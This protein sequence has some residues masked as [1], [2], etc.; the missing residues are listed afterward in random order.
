[1][2]LLAPAGTTDAF[3]AAVR[4]GADAV[5]IGAPALNAR[6]LA[7]DFTLAEIAAMVEEA[8]D[9]GVRVYAAMNALVKDAE[10]AAAVRLLAFFHSIGLD[11]V[12]LQDIGLYRLARRYFPDL[13]LHASTL[14]GANNHAHVEQLAAMGFARIV[15]AREMRL[16]EIAAVGEDKSCE[17]EVFVH[18]A[19]C[20]GV[21]GLCLFSSYLGGK[22]GLRGRCVQPCRR[23]YDWQGRGDGGYLFSMNDLEALPLVDDLRR[24]GV[25]SLKIEG[26]M[27]NASYV[28]HVVRA[29]RL[30]IDH[31]NDR[32]ALAE[33][34]SLTAAA[35]GRTTG[36]GYFPVTGDHGLISHR[37]SGNTGLFVGRIEAVRQ[38]RAVLSPRVTLAVGDRLRLHH[39]SSGDR[40]AFTVT[41]IEARPADRIVL[42]VPTQ[43]AAGDALY[44]IDTAAGGRG[45]ETK[46]FVPSHCR[47]LAAD[48][49][50]AP[51]VRSLMQRVAHEA[52]RPIKGGRQGRGERGGREH[53]PLWLK[54]DDLRH[55]THLPADWRPEQ[56]V[57]Q[58]SPDN[59]RRRRRISIP[60]DLASRLVLAL[61][62][63][64]QETDLW[65][66]EREILAQARRGQVDWQVA[67]IGQVRLFERL[68]ERLEREGAG[69]A[70]GFRG[71]G[72]GRRKKN[73]RHGR[74]PFS[75]FRLHGGFHLN[76]LNTQALKTARRAGLRSALTAIEADRGVVEALAA[77]KGDFVVGIT[78]YGRPALFISRAE[79]DFFRYNTVFVS[80][81]GERFSL[82]KGFGHTLALPERVFSLME[83]RGELAAMGLDY[84]VIDLCGIPPGRGVSPVLA[85][86]RPGGRRR[87]ENVG[88]F[89]YLGTLL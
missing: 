72:R 33:A 7:R 69:G 83:R 23:R 2:E 73:R 38:G 12:I 57:V 14:L 30:V 21:S 22:S 76:C 47:R 41:G 27:R 61:P 67:H 26:R 44:K 86:L 13:R 51:Q 4:A 79:A 64:I 11:A 77:G 84:G 8:H 16:D 87:K 40:H 85:D 78:V 6:A 49:D 19:M 46:N 62:P 75:G 17:I 28:E 60:G 29:Y 55:L 1:M 48:F 34:R 53:L 15:L 45:K 50:R 71:K 52:A 3:A 25:D 9:R 80:P 56:L 70:A 59:A 39:E 35:M 54:I 74:R 10:L 5:Y 82:V 32:E 36:P 31:G 24:A 89:N 18:G 43:A 42:P 88:T 65:W 68:A 58:V 66:Y 20:F 37:F 81:K 63:V